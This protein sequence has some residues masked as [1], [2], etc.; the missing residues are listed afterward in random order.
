[1]FVFLKSSKKFNKRFLEKKVSLF[2]KNKK[3][4]N[5]FYFLNK[6][7]KTWRIFLKDARETFKA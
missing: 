5:D 1:M 6:S 7:Q 3:S 4:S 2:C